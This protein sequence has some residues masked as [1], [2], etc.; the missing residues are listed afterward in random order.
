VNELF[1]PVHL[2]ILA[3][4]VAVLVMIPFWQIFKKAGFPA[5]LSLLMLV[6]LVSVVVLYFVAFS[7]WKVVPVP[8]AT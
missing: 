8:Q 6:P 3:A 4:I 5:P 1:V 2:L 7:A